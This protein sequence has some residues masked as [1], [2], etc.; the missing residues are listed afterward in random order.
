LCKH[1]GASIYEISSFNLSTVEIAN[2][3]FVNNYSEDGANI[4]VHH[5]GSTSS[6]YRIANSILWNNGIELDV[7]STVP[8]KKVEVVYSLVSG[9][10]DSSTVWDSNPLLLDIANRD[11][12]LSANS[13]VINSGSS[14]FIGENNHFDFCG[15]ERVF[16]AAEDIEVIE[17]E[18]DSTD[19]KINLDIDFVSKILE[20]RS[21]GTTAINY[22]FYDYSSSTISSKRGVITG[23]SNSPFGAQI[24]IDTMGC[25]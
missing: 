5:G 20:I 3:N 21:S 11:F 1:N 10:Y 9:G 25:E 15:N 13:P 14:D 7:N 2:S 22:E 12:R 6:K 8:A 19:L 24:E 4:F 18:C 17:K 16:N 23:Q